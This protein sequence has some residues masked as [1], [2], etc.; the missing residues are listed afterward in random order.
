MYTIRAYTFGYKTCNVTNIKQGKFTCIH[1]F[2]IS[3]VCVNNQ[4]ASILSLPYSWAY[5][6]FSNYYKRYMLKQFKK[7]VGANL[8]QRMKVNDANLLKYNIYSVILNLFLWLCWVLVAACGIYFPDQGSNP[9]PPALGAW[10]LSHWTTR[11]VP[12][13]VILNLI[14]PSVDKPKVIFFNN[15]SGCKF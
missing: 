7:K 15:L 13:S 14:F 12:Y 11:E 8:K 9:G 5:I 1:T 3:Q 4:L 10:S 2:T 6:V